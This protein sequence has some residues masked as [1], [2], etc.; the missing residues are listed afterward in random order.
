V[1]KP[2]ILSPW[3]VVMRLTAGDRQVDTGEFFEW[4]M[5]QDEDEE[6]WTTDRMRARLFSSVHDAHR[7]ARASGG[8]VV[9]LC[10]GEDLS[11]Y[12]RN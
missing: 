10:D 4:Y 7:V 1:S 9:A 6:P 3:F 11:E 12:R 8:Y 2:T 5:S